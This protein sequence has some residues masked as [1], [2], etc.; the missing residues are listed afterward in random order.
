MIPTE[1]K[2]KYAEELRSRFSEERSQTEEQAF[3]QRQLDS[4]KKSILHRFLS[5]DA[6]QRLAN[7]RVAHAELAEQVEIALLD[8]AQTG[9][10]KGEISDMQLRGILERATS[11]KKNFKFIK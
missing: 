10:L 1:L 7:V 5:R 11:E 4:A 6:R 9:M 8:A 3:V 2:K